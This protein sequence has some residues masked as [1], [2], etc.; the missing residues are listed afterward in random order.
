MRKI[1]LQEWISLEGYVADKDD[2]LTFFTSISN[3]ANKYSDLDQVKF[4][5]NIDTILLGRITYEMFVDFW[6][7]ADSEK[8]PIAQSLNRTPKLVFS[9]TLNEANWGKWENA[10]VVNGDAVEEIAKLKALPG[11]NMVI[12]GSIALTQSL[13]KCGLIDEYHLQL[14]P[15]ALGGGRP[16]F[17]AGDG[18]IN[19]ELIDLK[20]YDT[21]IVLLKYKPRSLS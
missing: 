13:M 11:K 10:K 21:G 6:P 2:Q 7:T 18:Y 3:E 15:V 14:C 4:M 17:P 8:E 19:L 9:N 12:W 5:D 1:I 20:K 16:L